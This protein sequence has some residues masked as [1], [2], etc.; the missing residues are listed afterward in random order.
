M[1]SMCARQCHWPIFF[2]DTFDIIAGKSFE[3]Q[4]NLDQPPFD[5]LKIP[6]TADAVAQPFSGKNNDDEE[7][8]D[9][10]QHLS[11]SYLS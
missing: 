7:E 11:K 2:E 4:S 10:I 6:V 5:T 9:D 8:D 1:T 3:Q